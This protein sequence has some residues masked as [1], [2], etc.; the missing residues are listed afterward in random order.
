MRRRLTRR[1]TGRAEERHL[2]LLAAYRRARD[3]ARWA[4]RGWPAMMHE[5]LETS[6]NCRRNERIDL[7]R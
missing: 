4:S 3:L 1:C 7:N 5:K 2:A 6:T